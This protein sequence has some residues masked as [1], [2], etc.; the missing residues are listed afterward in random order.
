MSVNSI[1][2]EINLCIQLNLIF[3]LAKLII[4][5]NTDFPAYIT[6]KDHIF[7]AVVHI[8]EAISEVMV[9]EVGEE[10][11][12]MQEIKETILRLAS[13]LKTQID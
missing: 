4:Y 8:A 9:K 10:I 1:N 12:N 6:T 3:N 7:Y 5:T 13:K 11:S 2:K